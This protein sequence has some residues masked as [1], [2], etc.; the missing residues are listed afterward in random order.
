MPAAFLEIDKANLRKARFLRIATP[1]GWTRIAGN[2]G[3]LE[4]LTAYIT[5]L[6][7][8]VEAVAH[9]VMIYNPRH[10]VI[11]I[12]EREAIEQSYDEVRAS[13][14]PSDLPVIVLTAENGVEAWQT[15]GNQVDQAQRD[16]WMQMQKELSELTTQGQWI[17]VEDSGHYLYMDRPDAVINAIL[18]TL[19]AKTN[20]A[21]N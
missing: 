20:E 3:L 12:A 15:A 8:D 16:A 21:S 18:S 14:L 1:L 10:W 19:S 11:S 4:P 2:L 17:I 5:P 7:D 13:T 6:P 9:A